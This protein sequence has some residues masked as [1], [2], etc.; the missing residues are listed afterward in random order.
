MTSDQI[1]EGENSSSAQFVEDFVDSGY[2]ELSKNADAIQLLVVDR[3]SNPTRFFWDDNHR[4]RAWRGGM[5]YEAGR[6]I[7]SKIVP[8]CL[9]TREFTR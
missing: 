6:E 3:E 1:E 5:L 7:P 8:I 9:T 2:G 4:A